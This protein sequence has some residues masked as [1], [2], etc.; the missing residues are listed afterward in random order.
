MVDSGSAFF[1]S[2]P[3]RL[4]FGPLLWLCCWP[5]VQTVCLHCWLVLFLFRL[6]TSFWFPCLY[7][8]WLCFHSAIVLGCFPFLGCGWAFSDTLFGCF[9]WLL[10][11]L[12]GDVIWSWAFSFPEGF[13]S[14]VQFFSV[15]GSSFGASCRIASTDATILFMWLVH[16]CPGDCL[17]GQYIVPHSTLRHALCVRLAMTMTMTM[18]MT[19]KDIYCQSCTKKI[20]QSYKYTSQLKGQQLSR[21]T[22]KSNFDNGGRSNDLCAPI[23]CKRQVYIISGEQEQSAK[24]KVDN[25][26]KNNHK[27]NDDGNN[28]NNDKNNNNSNDN[29]NNK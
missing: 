26:S 29:N 25:N 9:R 5:F 8:V 13:Y 6:S 12:F 2:L 10:W 18:T 11:R 14:L 15:N 20:R 28:D 21:S 22:M 7:T 23:S 24:C 4:S 3:V 16:F 27:D 1:Y 19:M 17:L